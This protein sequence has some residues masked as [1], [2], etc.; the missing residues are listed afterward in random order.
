MAGAVV[1]DVD[2]GY[3]A[4]LE[5]IY[6]VGRTKPVVRV[7]IQAKDGDMIHAVK[8]AEKAKAAKRA[9]TAANTESALTI[10]EIAVIN[11]FG[12]AD[13]KIPERPFLR[14]WFDENRQVIRE[15]F[16]LLMRSVVKGERTKEEILELVG[17]WCVGQI[18]AYIAR[19]GDGNYR[20]NAQ[21]TIDRKG[22]ST[23]LVD[24]GVMRSSI[25]Y[26][27]DR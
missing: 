25:T 10:L 1:R 6:G 22:S 12:S 21:R 3:K 26:R 9:A 16:G 11:E 15:R 19:R 20:E 5:R 17:L 24:T 8:A 13:G 2:H 18:Q 27:V 4:T 7:G 14:G 23:P